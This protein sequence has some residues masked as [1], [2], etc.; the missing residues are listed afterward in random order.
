MTVATASQKEHKGS[1]HAPQ[2][3]EEDRAIIWRAKELLMHRYAITEPQ[4]HR[5]LQRISMDTAIP[6]VDIA[7][8]IIAVL[9]R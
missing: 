7:R 2:R 6:M 9:D 8:Q 3:S 5:R 4:A 1:P